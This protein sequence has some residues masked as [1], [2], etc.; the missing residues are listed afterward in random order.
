MKKQ[1]AQVLVEFAL[2]LPLFLLILLGII[3]SGMLF[4]DYNTLSNIARSCAREAAVVGTLD[5]SA[6]SNIKG[7]Y[8]R[9]S[10]NHIPKSN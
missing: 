1:K 2:I 6:I 4:H 3:Y 9:T 5:E 10:I 7:H 8:T